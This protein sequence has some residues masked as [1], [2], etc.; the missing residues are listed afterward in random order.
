MRCNPRR[1]EVERGKIRRSGEEELGAGEAFKKEKFCSCSHARVG[2]TFT[3]SPDN[4]PAAQRD[5]D[6]PDLVRARNPQK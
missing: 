5:L 3:K 6:A 1:L 2:A 4:R